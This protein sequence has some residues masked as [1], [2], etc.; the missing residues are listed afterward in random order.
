MRIILWALLLTLTSWLVI[1][2]ETRADLTNLISGYISPTA[3]VTTGAGV[4]AVIGANTVS[5][6]DTASICLSGGGGAICNETRGG[7][8][9]VYGKQE[10]SQTG[11]VSIGTATGS[12]G[13]LGLRTAG[14]SR[15][16]I[17]STGTSTFTGQVLSTATSDLGW[18]LVSVANQACNT[19]CTNACVVGQETTSKALL[20]CT[21]ATA[22]I[23]LCA[24]AS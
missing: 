5:G 1:P 20:A 15:L 21:D 17:S 8:I 2:R 3:V 4:A 6:T 14:S 19:T 13:A 23:C 16:S 7:Y 18:T 12:A 10:V 11:G 9:A 24:G 22:D